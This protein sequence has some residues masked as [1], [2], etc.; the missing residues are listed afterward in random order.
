ML[1][2][3][4]FKMSLAK[5]TFILLYSHGDA[6]GGI[7]T[8]MKRIHDYLQAEQH[9]CNIISGKDAG[10]RK[11]LC[12]PM[13]VVSDFRRLENIT[14]AKKFVADYHI[15]T[16]DYVIS[17]DF[18]SALSSLILSKVLKCTP[19][20]TNWVPDYYWMLRSRKH[21][22]YSLLI[23]YA[24]KNY[25]NKSTFY[26][27]VSKYDIERKK[28]LKVN[29][30]AGVFPIPINPSEVIN[31]NYSLVDRRKIVTI[32]RFEKMKD[33]VLHIPE[34]V[35]SIHDQGYEIT[36]DMYGSG[37]Y[38]ENVDNLIKKLNLNKYIFLK[39]EV[40][41]SNY[42]DVLENAGIF[43]GMGT[44]SLEAAAQKC[45]TIYALP[46]CLKGE[47]CGPVYNSNLNPLADYDKPTTKFTNEVC[48]LL[49]L[50]PEKYI[51]EC[52]K[53][54]NFAS[55]F[56]MNAVMKDFQN[57]IR[58]NSNKKVGIFFCFLLSFYSFA[59]LFLK[60]LFASK[61]K[62]RQLDLQN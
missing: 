9:Q 21:H 3:K 48:H 8:L 27:M 28:V 13:A 23:S 30:D 54:Y 38:T 47:S 62:F 60:F 57:E 5:K 49:K 53:N 50:N 16:S 2:R 17:F 19:V 26:N 31:R 55:Q 33:Y 52:E 58:N 45:P 15:H 11:I 1:E 14:F 6:L 22:P 35:K 29:W 25:Y 61:K 18:G 59:R 46:F 10:F 7:E 12:P 41:Y 43:I 37:P 56:F 32:C 40:S 36:V 51:K 24:F 39:G 4:I 42:P 44:T 34:M 20:I